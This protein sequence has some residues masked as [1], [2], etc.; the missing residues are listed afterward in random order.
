MQEIEIKFQVNNLDVIKENLL[1]LG[2]EFSEELNQKDT[3]FVPDINDTS[4]QEGK[5]FIRIRNVNEKTELNLKQQ[6]KKIM[7][8]KEIEFEVSDFDAAY[9][10][11]DTL[12]LDEWVTVE[13]KRITTKYKEFNICIDEVKR[14]G[15]FIE[16]EIVTPEEDQTDYYEEEIVK[17]AKE[18]GINPDQRINNFYDTMI[19]ELNEKE[20]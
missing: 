20:Q 10:F 4:N 5:Q 1:R 11:L 19:S 8:S 3:V 15:E 6:S 13:K 9:D 2:C 14:L 12:G 7:Q 16:I 17:V 18:L